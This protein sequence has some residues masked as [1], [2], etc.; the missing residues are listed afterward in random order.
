[1]EIGH[2]VEEIRLSN[3]NSFFGSMTQSSNIPQFDWK[4]K[5][6][7][8]KLNLTTDSLGK[9]RGRGRARG[10]V[11]TYSRDAAKLNRERKDRQ[12]E[13]IKFS[14]LSF[15]NMTFSILSFANMTIANLSGICWIITELSYRLLIVLYKDQQYHLLKIY[16]P[17]F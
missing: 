7:I 11:Q 8:I 16:S 9:I 6:F 5:N 17:S 2:M 10:S 12:K 4:C 14:I 3:L 15:A 13:S 1:M